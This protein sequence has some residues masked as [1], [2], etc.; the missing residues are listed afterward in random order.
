MRTNRNSRPNKCI[1]SDPATSLNVNRPSDQVKTGGFEVVTASTHHCSLRDAHVTLQCDGSKIKQPALFPQPYVVADLNAPV[2]VALLI[3]V[4]G[5]VVEPVFARDERA[6]RPDEAVA[7]YAQAA[8]PV[9][10]AIPVYGCVAAYRDSSARVVEQLR[11]LLN[12]DVVA[13]PYGGAA[14]GV[15]HAALLNY[16]VCAE[17]YVAT[18]QWPH[19]GA[20]A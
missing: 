13:E 11:V 5:E 17:P 20:I 19:V 8:A 3:D 7:A 1:C 18:L 10:E 2:R 9:E 16:D 4:H 15:K 6:S 12:D 14:C